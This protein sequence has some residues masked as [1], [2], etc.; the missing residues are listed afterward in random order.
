MR[1]FLS[2]TTQQLKHCRDALASD[3]RA[4]GAEVRVQDD[5][6]QGT[7]TLLEKLEDYISDCD[8]VVAL[9][10]S[11]YGSEPTPSERP[12]NTPRRS[13]T[14]WEYHLARGE[15]LNGTTTAAIPTCV[16]FASDSFLNETPITQPEHEEKL[17]QDFIQAILDSGKDHLEFSSIHELGRFVLRDGMR[18]RESNYHINNLPPSI[19]SIFHGRDHLI[20]EIQQ[21]LNGYS[22]KPLVLFGMGGIGKTRLALEYAHQHVDSRSAT[23]F[24]SAHTPESLQTDLEALTSTNVLNTDEPITNWLEENP[25][26]LLIID[27][28]DENASVAAVKA[29]LPSLRRGN[30]LITSRNDRWGPTVQCI[31]VDVLDRK[32]AI[33]FLC[34]RTDQHRIKTRGDTSHAGQITDDM[35]NLPL[36]LEHAGA[37]INEQTISFDEYRQEWKTSNRNVLEWHDPD[38]MT[39]DRQVATTWET[40][41]KQ[42]G[43][44]GMTLLNL[45]SLLARATVP[46]ALFETDAAKQQFQELVTTRDSTHAS[47]APRSFREGYKQLRRYSLARQRGTGSRDLIVHPLV[48]EITLHR[49][50][51][52]KQ[53]EYVSALCRWFVAYAGD[54]NWK[55][56][57]PSQWSLLLQHARAIDDHMQRLSIERDYDVIDFIARACDKGG[58]FDDAVRYAED[59]LAIKTTKLDPDDKEILGTKDFIVHKLWRAGKLDRALE[60]SQQLLEQ[61]ES[62]REEDHYDIVST[63]HNMADILQSQGR[64]HEALKLLEYVLKVYRRILKPDHKHTLVCLNDLASAQLNSGY[65]QQ[66]EQSLLEALAGHERTDTVH[67]EDGARV[68]DNLGQLYGKLNRWNDALPYLQRAGRV[69]ES[70]YGADHPYTLGSQRDIAIAL[71]HLEMHD[72]AD[73]L[74]RNAL[75]ISETASELARK[76]NLHMLGYYAAFLGSI[77]KT[78]DAEQLWKQTEQRCIHEYGDEHDVTLHVRLA[79]GNFY[80]ETDRLDLSEPILRSVYESR[81]REYGEDHE[82]TLNALF[83]LADLFRQKGQRETAKTKCEQGLKTLESADRQDDLALRFINQLINILIEND[84]PEEAERHIHNS[85]QLRRDRLQTSDP[86]NAL[87][88]NS[89]ALALR[90]MGHYPQATR[91]LREAISI[92][93]KYLPPEH[94]KRP[95]RRNNRAMVFMLDD[96]LE[97]SADLVAEAWNLKSTIS[98]GGHD[99]TSARLLFTRLALDWLCDADPTVHLGQLKTLLSGQSLDCYGSIDPIW[100]A[101]DIIGKLAESLSSQRID[102][103]KAL[104]DALNDLDEVDELDA[105]DFWAK[106][107]PV[108]LDTPW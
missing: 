85:L 22:A 65:V 28:V 87:F 81:H 14:Q 93:D 47:T 49:L 84:Q 100:D 48:Q 80:Q 42:L 58:M 51:E 75:S 94:A 98:D 44:Q 71:Y 95:H 55:P 101:D 68:L 24:V 73:R 23:L 15:R 50:S 33:A 4:M 10:G 78:S 31:D 46:A 19:G 45:S 26:W 43:P 63:Q 90:R 35:G 96:Q 5:F 2:A 37:Y 70:V 21:H 52:D 74:F 108:P 82:E 1:I 107:Q 77:N 9:V 67:S 29:Q 39:Y 56:A 20:A 53:V 103:L 18:L 54:A 27:N 8:R 72:E 88:L 16:Y 91:M 11:A 6:Q 104:I 40:S 64:T 76:S 83:Y 25:G 12:T 57:N 106:Q 34:A 102:F 3:L 32:D 66:G 69:R 59:S 99:M 60:I 86:E 17:Q 13:Y 36:G 89:H 97:K 41:I 79:I 38:F 92:E 61:Y 105:F 30:I 62:L 7:G